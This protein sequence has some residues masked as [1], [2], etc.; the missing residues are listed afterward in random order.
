MS[1]VH[2]VH[3]PATPLSGARTGGPGASQRQRGM[4]LVELMVALLLGLVTTYFISQVF[5]VAEG[6]K[7]TATFGSDAQINGSVALHT[8]RRHIM[9]AGYGVVSAAS[10]LGCPITGRFGTSGSAVVAPSMTLAP[11]IITPGTSASA[12]S[13]TLRVLTSTKSTFA[14]PVKTT[15]THSDTDAYASFGVVEGSSQGISLGDTILAIPTNWSATT[16]CLLLTVQQDTSVTNTTL[17]RTQVPHVA[18]PSASSWNA[19]NSSDWPVGGFQP[20]SLL[21]NFG[22]PRR[23]DFYVDGDSFKVDTWLQNTAGT[24]FLSSGIVLLKA[25][26]GRDTDGNGTVDVYDTNTP[27]D[28]ASWRN[29]LAVRFVVVARSGQREKDE[30]TTAE[31][32]WNAAGSAAVTYDKYPGARTTCAAGAATCDL[33]LAISQLTDW[34]HYRYKV[35]DT[36]VQVRNLMWNV[37]E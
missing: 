26:Y 7:R 27:T 22:N 29:V 31:P 10:A 15:A 28:N 11:V 1:E 34:K 25:L 35:F 18:S 3:S 5:A 12:P 16:K 21:V 36:A 9:S 6:Q 32:T 17:S 19:T 23:M 24:E 33:P 8:L 37:E 14:A 2:I 13:D 30:V 20:N 4:T